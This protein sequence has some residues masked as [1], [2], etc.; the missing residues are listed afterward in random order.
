MAPEFLVKFWKG[1]REFFTVRIREILDA[2]WIRLIVV[3]TLLV[4]FVI[5]FFIV[6]TSLSRT[7]AAREE[8]QR[9]QA[10]GESLFEQAGRLD[11]SDY[12]FPEEYNLSDQ[13][14][15]PAREPREKWT[16]EE[17]DQYWLDLTEEDVTG[18]SEI[19]HDMIWSDLE[20][21]P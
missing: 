10:F 3:M 18:V 6:F 13:E 15:Y 2:R 17:V 19:N 11:M 5:I 8:I 1:V 9:E 14:F 7:R 20:G 4:T 16:R 12:I 21:V